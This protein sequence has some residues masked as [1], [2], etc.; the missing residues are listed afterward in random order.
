M[1][2][3]IFQANKK[4]KAA[5]VNAN[6]AFI[7]GTRLIAIN[8][9]TGAPL[10]TF[11]IGDLTAVTNGSL[12]GDLLG[13]T[14]SAIKVYN[15][16]GVL[17]GSVTYDT[18]LNLQDASETAKGV[19]EIATQSEVNT[20][21]DD[22][23]FVTALKLT[24]W[25]NAKDY[26]SSAQAMTVGAQTVLA[27][28]L[29]VQPKS[30]QIYLQCVTAQYGYTAGQQVLINPAINDSSDTTNSRGFS[31]IVDSTNITVRVGTIALL[32]IRADTGGAVSITTANW[33]F[34]IKA[35]K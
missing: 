11:P 27:H 13:R 3:T 18:L 20:G 16:S 12:A 8:G 19:A 5:E 31:I 22:A 30:V 24:T 32:F 9:T 34:V 7:S 6:F 10:G 35:K 25:S 4:A 17:I 15:A 29:G 33:N 14:G 1:A 28:G 2:F 21:T 23:R 26:V